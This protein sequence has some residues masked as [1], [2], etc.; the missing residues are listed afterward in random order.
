M[1]TQPTTQRPVS[2][3]SAG[4]EIFFWYVSTSPRRTTSDTKDRYLFSKKFPEV[5][6]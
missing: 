2:F 1:A 6:T 3:R 4:F 5:I